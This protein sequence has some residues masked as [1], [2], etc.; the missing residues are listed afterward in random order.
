MRNYS[1]IFLAP[2]SMLFPWLR[3]SLLQSLP[4]HLSCRFWRKSPLGPFFYHDPGSFLLDLLIRD[5]LIA[6]GASHPCTQAKFVSDASMLADHRLHSLYQTC[7]LSSKVM[8]G[9][10]ASDSALPEAGAARFDAPNRTETSSD[11]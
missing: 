10:A 4:P 8:R 6:M 11:A 1:E 7:A 9:L 3:P 2:N 5:F